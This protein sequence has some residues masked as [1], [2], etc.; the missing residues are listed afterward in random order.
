VQ[1]HPAVPRQV[2]RGLRH[3]G[4]VG[5]D[6]RAVDGEVGEL[7]QELRLPG[8]PRLQHRQAGRIGALGDR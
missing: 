6:R 2:E 5:H 7:R 4:A 8:R 3:E 1:V